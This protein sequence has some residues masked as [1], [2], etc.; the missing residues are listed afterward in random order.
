VCQWNFGTRSQDLGFD[1]GLFSGGSGDFRERGGEARQAFLGLIRAH[2]FLPPSSA[3]HKSK[4]SITV[5]FMEYLGNKKL[6]LYESFIQKMMGFGEF[7]K[8]HIL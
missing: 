8:W 3:Y 6:S 7:S 4:L 1:W 2:R 5:M